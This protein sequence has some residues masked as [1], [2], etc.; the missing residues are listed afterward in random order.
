MIF[1]HITDDY[2]L[3]GILAKLKQKDWWK[4]NA[5][6]TLYKNDYIIA[7][8]EHGFSWTFM[9]FLPIFIAYFLG[10]HVNIVFLPIL[11]I[12]NLVCHVSIDHCKANL[13][14]INLTQ[15][16]LFHF[17]QILFTAIILLK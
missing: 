12:L 2:Y 17:A 13:R 3:Q 5:P 16:Q 4:E 15:D 8:I 10:I 14:I 7:L 9:I 1:C 6:N 11:F